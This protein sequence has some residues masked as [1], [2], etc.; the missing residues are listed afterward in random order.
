MQAFATALVSGQVAL[1]TYVSLSVRKVL[2]MWQLSRALFCG[3]LVSGQV[4]LEEC[5][6]LSVRSVFLLWLL[7]RAGLCGCVD[8]WTN[9]ATSVCVSIG[10]YSFLAVAAVSC[11]VV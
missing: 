1:Q 2:L 7:S 4:P 3:R 8:F 9:A 5:T 10:S 6:S 11:I